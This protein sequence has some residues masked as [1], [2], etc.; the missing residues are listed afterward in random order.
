MAIYE[1]QDV[2]SGKMVDVEMPMAE[3]VDIG[4]TI[5]R[6]G[7]TLK[8]LVSR[9]CI[10]AAQVKGFGTAFVAHSLHR[11]TPGVNHVDSAGRVHIT[12]AQ[13]IRDIHKASGIRN[14]RL[15]D[16]K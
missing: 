11:D 6:G 7:R 3:A 2:E 8:R 4:S 9:E 14:E 15:S 13:D 5:R 12:C 10:P 16:T 1:F